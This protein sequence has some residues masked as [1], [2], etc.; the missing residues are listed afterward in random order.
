V[1]EERLAELVGLEGEQ[2][3]SVLAGHGCVEPVWEAA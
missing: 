3:G 2:I 1:A